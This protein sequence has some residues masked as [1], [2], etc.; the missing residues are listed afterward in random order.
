MRSQHRIYR[1]I[2]TLVPDADEADDLLQQVSMTLWQ[3][4]DDFDPD[5]AQFIQWALG[6]ARNHVR[7]YIRTRVRKKKHVVFD[8]ALVEE[9]ADVRIEEEQHFEE[10]R[11]A[12]NVCLKRLSAPNRALV[13][14]FYNRTASVG[15]IA[16]SYGISGRSLNRYVSRIRQTLLDCILRSLALKVRD[17]QV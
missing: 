14:N 5:Q 10:Q 13:E 17:E 15:E 12:L 16:R 1:F 2:M 7:N 11:E 8:E 6:V 9:L 4:W 3:R